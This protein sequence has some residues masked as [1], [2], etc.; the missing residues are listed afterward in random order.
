[1]FV[2]EIPGSL[3]GAAG[4]LAALGAVVMAANAAAAPVHMAVMPP[5]PED[6]TAILTA[7]MFQ[8]N[9]A[10]YQS[11]QG[12]GALFHAGTVATTAAAGES[13]DATEVASGVGLG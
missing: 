1:M 4:A 5:A 6:P 8:Q 11:M 12:I 7:L 2:T 10:V 3:E 9:H 13:Y